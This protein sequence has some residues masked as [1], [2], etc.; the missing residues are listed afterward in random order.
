[1]AYPG[2]LMFAGTEIANVA[3][4]VAYARHA[5]PSMVVVDT[6]DSEDLPLL[7]GD[8][9]Y[10]SPATD[11]AP[12][13]SPYDPDSADFFGFY[14]LTVQGLDD[15]T[16]EVT[17]TELTG[18][19]AVLSKMR[20]ASRSIRVSGLIM[21]ASPAALQSGKRWLRGA[22]AAPDCV[23][24]DCNGADLCYLSFLPDWCDFS[25]YPAVPVDKANLSQDLSLWDPVGGAV[26][27]AGAT[28]L[29]FGSVAGSGARRYLTGLIPGQ[30]YRV[31]FDLASSSPLV[32][33]D[34]SGAGSATW[35]TTAEGASRTLG[36]DGPFMYDFVAQQ[37]EH[38]LTITQVSPGTTTL[39]A[40]R[41]S[42]TPGMRAVSLLTFP[43][44]E[45]YEPGS[46]TGSGLPV[47]VAYLGTLSQSS[48]FGDY[49]A[50]K[51]LTAST[52]PVTVDPTA[53]IARRIRGL[54]A[55]RQYTATL[56]VGAHT[57]IPVQVAIGG[58][59]TTVSATAATPTWV[60]VSFVATT[61]YQDVVVGFGTSTTTV[62]VTPATVKVSY[63]RVDM[64]DPTVGFEDPDLLE[65]ANRTLRQVG[66]IDGPKLVE[67]YSLTTGAME[68][69]E[70]TLSGAP[71]AY[72]PPVEIAPDIDGTYAIIPDTAC[73]LGQPVRHN[74]LPNSSFEVDTSSW[75]AT[76]AG[77]TQVTSV[78]HAVPSGTA[79]GR[80]TVTGSPSAA[81]MRSTALTVVPFTAYT[82]SVYVLTSQAAQVTVT[83]GTNLFATILGSA[84]YQMEASTTA[85]MRRLEVAAL[86]SANGTVAVR[87]EVRGPTGGVPATGMVI[88][89]DAAQFETGTFASPY[90]N[91]DTSGGSWDGAANLST[92]TWT[93][94]ATPLIV[95]PDCTPIPPPP[96]APL[97]LDDCIEAPTTWRR[98]HTTIPAQ[99]VPA[100][101]AAV[102]VITL[103]TAASE[104]R[105]VRLRFTAV[106]FDRRVD[107][108]NPC[109]YCGEFIVSYIPPNSALVIDSVTEAVTIDVAAT[110]TQ[111]AQNLLYG[112]DGGPVTW[113]T[114]SCEV[115]Y[116]MTVDAAPAIQDLDVRL[117]LAR[118][119]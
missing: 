56:A 57:S 76:G 22:L 59:S 25:G 102:P 50:I 116:V 112:T 108:M 33:L 12:W 21:G 34:V 42:R 106:P 115:Q 49:L 27:S 46:W 2:W 96:R 24:G 41:V 37:S 77:L 29:S 16:T 92:S 8:G 69:V 82:F 11:D 105:Q 100:W 110:G 67:E 31:A 85:Q 17:V 71:Y 117:S 98:Y 118:R 1:M 95:D 36:L 9:L 5:L 4:T 30:S 47:G 20:D 35:G 60:Q 45:V 101:S 65:V 97:V 53:V 86:P 72:A 119:D 14:P 7:L 81:L 38:I 88:D 6:Y 63:L 93:S 26:L 40:L 109:D 62:D 74:L 64:D 107:Q 13:Y 75:S 43:T 103:T 39:Y 79:V 54:V 51:Y 89:V 58:S 18:P 55:G 48:G 90:F 94:P 52:T 23:T 99:A 61:Y 84:T 68:R 28:S 44:D 70:F 15:A 113:P 104:V 32:R 87:V 111:T 80:L 91:G 10:S 19:G 73:V 114:L 78:T 83:V 66:L 3:R